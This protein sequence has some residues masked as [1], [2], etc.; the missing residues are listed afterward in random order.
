MLQPLPTPLSPYSYGRSLFLPY[1]PLASTGRASRFGFSALQIRREAED[2][3]GFDKMVICL[4]N[5]KLSICK[6]T[7]AK[8]KKEVGKSK[9]A[10]FQITDHKN[11]PY[12]QDLD[13]REGRSKNYTITCEISRNEK[14]DNILLCHGFTETARLKDMA[15][16]EASE[17]SP[18]GQSKAPAQQKL[19][20]T[21]QLKKEVVDLRT[22]L[23]HCAQAV[24]ADNRLLAGEIIKKIRQHSS[25]DGEW[26][27]RLAFYL[28]NGLEARLAG[29]GSQLFHKMRAKQVSY[30]DM[31]KVYNFYLA[32]CPFHKA[33][34][35][36]AN[37]TILEASV[38]QSKVHIVD[39]GVCSAFQW[40]SL[41]QR[42]GEQG[43]PP[44]LRI[45]DIIEVPRPGF[46]PLESIEW[47]GKLL[48]DY[49]NMYKVPFQYQGIYSRYEDIQIEDLNIEEDEMLIIHCM[50]RMKN[51]G[52]ETVAMDSA[53]DRVLK[54]MR[55]MN[56]KVFIV[57][58]LNGSYSS[59][60]FLTRFKELLFH[61][62]SMF[63]MLD[64]N[65]PRDNEE[66]KVLEG[67]MLGRDMLNIIAC[68]GVDRIER[69]ETYRQWQARCLKAGFEQLPLDPAIMKS[70][71]WMKKEFYHE[72]FVADED[73]GW[74][75]QGWKGRVLY[76]LSKWKVNESCADQ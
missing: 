72:D 23:I 13:T 43:M 18:K 26:C 10:I 47:A 52:D 35:T 70:V 20:G 75:L 1:Q 30:E 69:P 61:Y 44:R 46:N 53:R 71:L 17:N 55:R 60:F 73:S 74:L 39:F 40:P 5:D 15:A 12:I 11:N 64:T 51:L 14:F 33:S 32:V 16:K 31:L 42:F 62:S 25:R 29:T 66:R 45:T 68:E 34:Q 50:Y 24:A 27:Q 59:P 8:A 22:L 21:R 48:A 28:V 58:I 2:G 63:D 36:F 76:A 4:D 41:I 3:K 65:A 9:Y 49:A 56:P 57:G 67:G 7:T 37:Q 19:R 38:G 54:I 6:L